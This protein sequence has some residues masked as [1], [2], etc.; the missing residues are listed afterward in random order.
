[1]GAVGAATLI[2]MIKDIDQWASRKC[3]RQALGVC[4]TIAE[5]GKG[6][7]Q[8]VMGEEGICRSPAGAMAGDHV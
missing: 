5:S 1:L 4:P 7:G 3:L 8:S 6:A 2:G